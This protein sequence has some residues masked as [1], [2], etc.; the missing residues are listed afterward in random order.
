MD[1]G[2]VNNMLLCVFCCSHPRFCCVITN[3]LQSL[4]LHSEYDV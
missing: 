1:D 2:D 4:C 3:I